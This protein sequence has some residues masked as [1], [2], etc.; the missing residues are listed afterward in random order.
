MSFIKGTDRALWQTFQCIF[1]EEVVMRALA[2]FLVLLIA[3][4]AAAFAADD[5]L[6]KQA[7]STFEPIPLKPPAIKDVTATPAMIELGQA[8]YFDPRLS[9]RMSR[10]SA[11]SS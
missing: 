3:G 4:I 9:M 1:D 5:S 2:S 11:M 10:R 7:Q 6:M 8:L